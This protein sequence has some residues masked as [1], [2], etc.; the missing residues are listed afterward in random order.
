MTLPHC[1]H[2]CYVVEI[3]LKSLHVRIFLIQWPE[4]KKCNF[5][6]TQLHTD[7]KASEALPLYIPPTP[8]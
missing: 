6:N 4:K 5:K 8:A 1:L 7:K 2:M 3:I